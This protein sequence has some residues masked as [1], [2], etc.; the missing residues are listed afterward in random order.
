MALSLALSSHALWAQ[1]YCRNDTHKLVWI[2]IA[3]N[4]VPADAPGMLVVSQDNW[5][6][7]G[8]YSVQPVARYSAA[9]FA[10]WL[11]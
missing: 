10:Y 7:E 5:I 9:Q 4:H 11:R 3:Y 2:S 1:M 6:I 8:W